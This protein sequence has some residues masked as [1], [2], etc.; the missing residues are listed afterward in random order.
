MTFQ[1]EWT[2]EAWTEARALPA[3]DRRSVMEAVEA[4][5]GRAALA[6]RGRRPLDGRLGQGLEPVWEARLPGG[7]R[8]LYA[9]AAPRGEGGR[10]CAW[11]LR[12]LIGGPSGPLILTAP[13]TRELERRRRALS[14]LGGGIPHEVVRRAWLA[15]L[16]REP[17]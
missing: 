10:R 9:V 4:L 15:E 13:E 17:P 3:R 7:H 16:A 6:S 14:K 11:V 5:A 2:S 1:V 8:L 12:A